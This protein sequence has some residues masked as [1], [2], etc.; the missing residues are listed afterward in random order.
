MNDLKFTVIDAGGVSHE[1]FIGIREDY[2]TPVAVFKAAI[3]MTGTSTEGK[4]AVIEWEQLGSETMF[5]EDE[6]LTLVLGQALILFNKA[7]DRVFGK[8][9]STTSSEIL[10]MHTEME[11]LFG[12]ENNRFVLK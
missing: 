11:S 8:T 2:L 10:A 1:I 3:V 12:F 7:L 4:Q 9:S 6:R 5:Y